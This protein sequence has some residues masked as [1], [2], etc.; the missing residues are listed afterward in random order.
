MTSAKGGGGV[1]DKDVPLPSCKK[2]ENHIMLGCLLN[3]FKIRI[4]TGKSVQPRENVWKGGG[5]EVHPLSDP[6]TV[7]P[8]R[9][10]WNVLTDPDL[11]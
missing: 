8:S 3:H 5:G 9:L 7:E 11:I 4:N 10:I 2:D 6:A 1:W